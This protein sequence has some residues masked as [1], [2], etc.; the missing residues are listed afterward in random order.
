MALDGQ[1]K[2]RTRQHLAFALSELRCLVEPCIDQSD[3]PARQRK[4]LVLGNRFRAGQLGFG[5]ADFATYLL[6]RLRLLFRRCT[7]KRVTVLALYAAR[8]RTPKPQ[9]LDDPVAAQVASFVRTDGSLKSWRVNTSV[10][11]VTCLEDGRDS[12]PKF[13][14][15]LSAR[16]GTEHDHPLQPSGWACASCRSTTLCR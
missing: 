14:A 12:R 11:A 9:R 8:Y 7:G 10:A 2:V 4:A 5:Q 16:L 1:V 13:A 15:S 3:D 6:R